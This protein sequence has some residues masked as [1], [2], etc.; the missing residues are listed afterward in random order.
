MRKAFLFV[1]FFLLVIAPALPMVME[2]TDD[3]QSTTV[4]DDI[5]KELLDDL[6]TLDTIPEGDVELNTMFFT[7]TAL[8]ENGL[9]YVC[10][11]GTDAVAYFGAS[12]VMYLSGG[13][14][15]TLEFSGSRSVVPHGERPT[16][17]VT[18]YMY[19][20]DLSKWKT[21]IQDCAALR[22]PEIYPGIDLVYKIQD[23]NL[24]YE[25]VVSPHADPENIRLEYVD[26][27]SIA[28]SNDDLIITKDGHKMGDTQLR[29]FQKNGASKVGCKFFFAEDNIISFNLD[30]YD[31][32]EELIIDPIFLAYSTFLGGSGT[33]R[34]YGIAVDNGYVYVAGY[35]SSSNFPM[36]DAYNSTYLGNRD[37]FVTKFASD[38]QSLVYS[39]Y[40]GGSE[41]DEGHG[42]AVENGSAYVFGYT[43]SLDFPMVN[44]YNSTHGGSYDCFV[45]KFAPDGQTL[46]YSTY[47]GGSN[48]DE[49]QAITVENGYAYV[50]GHT[51]SSNF[52]TVN[53][54][55]LTYG[56]DRDCFVTKFAIDG[57]SLV[58][59][60]YLGGLAEDYGVGVAVEN[61]YAYVT[62]YTQS[63]DFPVINAYDSIQDGVWDCFVTKF[64][65]DGQ[66][67]VYSTYLG[68]SDSDRGY[69]IAVENGHAY[70][71]GYAQ[72]S[73][74]PTVN[75]YDSTQ[76]GGGYDCF[77]T[78]FTSDGQSLVY[79]TYVGAAGN[80]V[81]RGIVVEN[82]YVYIAGDT[83]SSHFPTVNAY[84]AI[85]SS[86]DCF[87]L[88]MTEDSD[89]DGLPNWEEDFL[90]GTDPYCIDSDN[91]NFLDAYEIAYGTS[92]TDPA[93]YPTMPQA[94]YD[95][96]Y[97]DLDGNTTLIQQVISWL[98]GN[99]TELALV[100]ALV[101]SNYDWLNALN[102]TTF[103]NFT[104]IREVM[105]MLGATI[106][107]ADYDGLDDLE[108]IALGTN[109]QCIDTDCDNLN[110]A[111][112][113]KIGTDPLD[114][115][116]DGDT[117]LDGIEVLAGTDPLDGN[118]YPG[119]TTSTTSSSPPPD[120]FSP[121]VLAIVIAGAG[122]G[123]TVVIVLILR[124]RR[125]AS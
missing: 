34:G 98:D 71:T 83:S 70:V 109:F 8:S 65:T 106:G 2:P 56:G 110:D 93:D 35:T 20:N 14:V 61:E 72:S 87:M 124:K 24:K 46:M 28:I 97:E 89:S 99:A 55:D 66:S 123:V 29:V 48:S 6:Q 88:I 59:S 22:Y 95:V 51:S 39:T 49:G 117:Y 11:R 32:T 58:Y 111:F 125:G 52:P 104:Q 68:G 41:G 63:W 53:A 33:E 101:T 77:V 121:M 38:G 27:D 85:W 67:L 74:F 44:A 79:S 7:E 21:G 84:D 73:D 57:Q 114:D 108:E 94:W 31:S 15:F 47:L 80:D 42:I 37:C 26:A 4:P 75:A 64:A 69:A 18:N 50:I 10:R 122:I 5:P 45:T 113:V 119:A 19:G 115:D 43:N 16:G 1:L 116:S 92:A 91:D 107:D 82:G 90:Y 54:Y 12:M 105:D 23:G 86:S 78:K 25:F 118:D 102:A 36:V 96:I 112:E 30:K 81:G 3:Y 9:Y 120:E 17:S 76:S 103:G 60:T 13:A 62:G 40:L 100:A